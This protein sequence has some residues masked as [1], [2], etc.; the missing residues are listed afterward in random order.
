[1]DAK[2][3][4]AKASAKEPTAKRGR[5]PKTVYSSFETLP[6]S[7]DDE[8]I[9]MKLNVGQDTIDLA[10][11]QENAVKMPGAYNEGD[12]FQFDINANMDIGCG[13]AGGGGDVGAGA[14]A[15]AGAQHQQHQP[16]QPHQQHQQHSHVHSHAH[17]AQQQQQQQ[18]LPFN[19]LK[20]VE[21][22]KDFEEKNKN[23]EWPN[24]TSIHC[25]WCCHKFDTPPFGIPVKYIDRKFEVYGCFCS[26]EC[27][28]AYN[29]DA[30]DGEHGEIWERNSLINFVAKRIGYEKSV[31]RAPSRL[32]LNIFGGHLNITDF[33]EYCHT[34]KLIN[35]NFPPMMTLTQQIEE[36]NESDITNEFK[37]IPVDT[38]RIDRY[39]QQLHLKRTKPI[40]S[41]E[42]TLDHA[43][44]LKFGVV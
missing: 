26:L 8:H 2:P 5:K 14:G 13:C 33:R 1:M 11:E 3:K 28:A 19:G 15:G 6:C 17:V 34:S 10:A 16:H 40:N 27:A 23:N 20:L 32:A 12:F 39:K 25:Y 7:S 29:F 44:N 41:H 22:L 4:S 21:I 42:N 18:Q 31:K 24:T 37:Y 35:I 9:I 38:N 30:K 36:V 43:M